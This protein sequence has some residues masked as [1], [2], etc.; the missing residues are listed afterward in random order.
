M[1]AKVLQKAELGVLSHTSRLIL[2]LQ[3][4]IKHHFEASSLG[5]VSSIVQIVV[6]VYNKAIIA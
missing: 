2:H 4:F 6:I 5:F 1:T 3:N